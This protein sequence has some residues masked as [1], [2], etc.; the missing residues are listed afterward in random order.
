MNS[1]MKSNMYDKHNNH[2]TIDSLKISLKYVVM[3]ILFNNFYFE[4][5]I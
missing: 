1:D 5:N 3:K 4:I 2:V